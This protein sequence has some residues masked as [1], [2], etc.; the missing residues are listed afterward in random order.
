MTDVLILT[1]IDYCPAGHLARVLDE[2]QVDFRVLRVDLGELDGCDL[3]R[4]K[5]V[6][7]MGGPMSVNDPLPW[8]ATEIDALR[9]FIR[10]DIPMIGH[11]LGGQLLAKALG[12][13]VHRMPYTEVG[14]QPLRR[15]GVAD[16]P[17]LGQL[18]EEFVVYQW[19]SDTFDL[20]EG[21]ERLL[22]SP[23]CPNQAFSWGD[24]VLALQ[25]HP[26]MTEELVRHW[27]S[28]WAHL[29]DE[30]QSSQQ[31]RRQ[32]LS[33]LPEKVAAL[34]SVAEHFYRH[35]LGLARLV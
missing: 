22:S 31:G 17:W 8:I 3:D 6:A 29:L 7:V 5:A 20:P 1:H 34:N 19:H 15:S 28:D 27:L 11:C 13:R 25:G 18:P 4:P 9:H 24:K 10:R 33:G 21:A 2:H 26:E 23:W 16:N 30:T 35:W 32:M 14:W 12:A